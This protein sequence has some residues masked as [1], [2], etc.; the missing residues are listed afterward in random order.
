MK[1]ILR[2]LDKLTVEKQ[3]QLEALVRRR[4]PVIAGRMAKD[5]F[6][7]NFKKGG[8]VNGGL[9]KWKEPKRRLRNDKSVESQYKTLMS[10]SPHL[11][12]SIIYIPGDRMVTIRNDVH[13]AAIHNEGGTINSHPA[14]TPRMR[15]YAW[16][17]YYNAGG[18]QNP[19]AQ[20]WKR[21][22]LTKKQRLDITIRMPKRQFIGESKELE[23][24]ITDRLE[25]EVG[26]IILK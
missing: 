2:Q 6:Q 22:A 21:L 11:Y 25:E 20:M 24:K 16:A 15:K 1:D 5:H 13:Y 8:F 7:D 12:S 26:K 14:V 17:Q 23:S 19:H 18:K 9:H 10:G 4:M 3:K